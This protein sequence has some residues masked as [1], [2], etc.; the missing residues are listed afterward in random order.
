MTRGAPVEL[1]ELLR[2]GLHA[3]WCGPGGERIVAQVLVDLPHDL[4][5]PVG[6]RAEQSRTHLLH[7][8]GGEPTLR[9]EPSALSDRG[10][11]ALDNDRAPR[12]ARVELQA[13]HFC[14]ERLHARHSIGGIGDL[15][16]GADTLPQLGPRRL[17][18]RICDVPCTGLEVGARLG[19]DQGHAA[20][21]A[22]CPSACSSTRATTRRASKCS[23]TSARAARPWC[24]YSV[25]A[26]ARAR[27]A[28]S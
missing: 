22:S 23:S 7:A 5:A 6:R 4:A 2:G 16:Q 13:V 28:S 9:Q 21:L 17:A 25:S 1:C 18:A 14:L 26:A 3:L 12:R 10:L 8:E 11:D 19:L 20:V 24:S 15:K 27:T